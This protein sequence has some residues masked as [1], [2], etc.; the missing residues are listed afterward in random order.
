MS[1]STKKVRVFQA[2]LITPFRLILFPRVML[3]HSLNSYKYVSH[4]DGL[5]SLKH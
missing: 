3:F 4:S 2:L 5:H 1:V